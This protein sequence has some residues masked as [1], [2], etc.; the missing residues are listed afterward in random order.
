VA[1]VITLKMP[2]DVR[3]ALGFADEF[4]VL[5]TSYDQS[6]IKIDNHYEILIALK[7]EAI[8]HE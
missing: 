5:P 1:Q 4:S 6:K 8:L 3:P 2:V 7:A